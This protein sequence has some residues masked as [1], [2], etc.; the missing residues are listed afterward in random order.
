MS[1][2]PKPRT[3][4]GWC[5]SRRS[6]G[7]SSSR[8]PA[9]HTACCSLQSDVLSKLDTRLVAPPVSSGIDA[10]RMPKR[11]CPAFEVEGKLC[12]LMPHEAG[13]VDRRMLQPRVQSLRRE[14]D[15]IISAV[16][17]ALSGI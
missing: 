9:V 12:V 6:P 7:L 15:R 8:R 14:A 11:L 16:D 1:R 4:L 17:A 5:W 13:P 2:R 10:S 3:A